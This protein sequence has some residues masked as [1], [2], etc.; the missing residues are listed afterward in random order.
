VKII[1]QESHDGEFA[2]L[3][4]DEFAGK[5]ERGIEVLRHNSSEH[6]G[7]D[8]SG[9]VKGS[10]KFFGEVAVIRDLSKVLTDGFEQRLEVLRKELVRAVKESGI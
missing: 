4:L 8:S 1:L 5:L 10:Q 7:H 9:L 3:S 2:N 6:F